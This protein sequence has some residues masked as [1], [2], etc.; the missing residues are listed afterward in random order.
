MMYSHIETVLTMLP[1][2][3]QLFVNDGVISPAD[4]E[5]ILDVICRLDE[6]RAD[7]P[8]IMASTVLARALTQILGEFNAMKDMGL[9][10]SAKD[11][12][13]MRELKLAGDVHLVD[14]LAELNGLDFTIM[15]Q[16]EEFWVQFGD[17]DSG[18]ALELLPN[19]NE[20]LAQCLVRMMPEV[21]ALIDCAHAEAEQKR[22]RLGDHLRVL[23]SRS[24]VRPDAPSSP[25]GLSRPEAT[26]GQ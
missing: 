21:Q 10:W 5:Q 4:Q 3:V 6:I 26:C 7:F 19:R 20:S 9:N 1:G 18:S 22:R 2:N 16:S 14:A 11:S 15:C 12:P 23:D 17:V 25:A 13:G 24:T 8:I